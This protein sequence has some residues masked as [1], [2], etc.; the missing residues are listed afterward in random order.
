M[1]V[2]LAD[3][4]GKGVPA[5]VFVS[6]TRAVVRAIA[7][8][9]ASPS[10]VLTVVS[11]ILEQDGAGDVYVTCFIAVVDTERRAMVYANAG[12]PPGIVLG[13]GGPLRGLG[14]GGP[15]LGLIPGARYVEESLP[16]AAGDIVV[17]VS[18]GITEAFD[19]GGHGIT[20]ALGAE[21]E[22]M[23][24]RTPR[25]VCETLL[26]RARGASGPPGGDQWSDDRTVVSFQCA[27]VPPTDDACATGS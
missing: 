19:V 10:A 7:R 18:D 4:S 14:A 6:N 24:T 25:A 3:V 26:S 20:A 5:A 9:Q 23:P 1:C 2:V 11:A 13:Q 15:P 12:H 17:V 27:E 8:E 16:L 22:L 21:L